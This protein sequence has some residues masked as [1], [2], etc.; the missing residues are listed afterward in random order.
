[1]SQEEEPNPF[2]PT[3]AS[4]SGSSCPDW[5]RDAKFG[6]WSHW[7]PQSVPRQGDW[8]ARGMYI[9]GSPH[10]RYHIR[11][12]GHP[13]EF[14]YKDV[15]RLWKAENFDPDA[16]MDL[17]VRAGA[18]YFVAQ[19]SHHDHFLN[20]ASRL[21][22][23][24]SVEVGPG[25]DIVGLWQA[26]ARRHG[27]PFGLSE[28]LAATFSW[29]PVNKAADT[30]GPWAGVPY[31][32]ADP[33]HED[34]Y[35][36]NR[37][38]LVPGCQDV[39]VSPWYTT[40]PWWHRRW[41]DL[42]TEMIDLYQP[43]LL[44]TDGP[45]PFFPHG[46]QPA[47][48]ATAHLYNTSAAAHDG[49]NQAVF[50]H[51]ERHERL[52]GFGVL[53]VERSQEPRV[54]PVPWQTDT[55]LGSWF[56]DVNAVYKTPAHVIEL[57]VDIVAKNGNLLLNVPQLPDGT[58]DR[59]CRHLLSELADWMAFHGE[60]IHGTR[61]FREG[62]EG[63]SGVTIDGFR[64]DRVPWTGADYRFTHRGNTVYAFQMAWPTDGRAV[65]HSVNTGDKVTRV[66]LLGTGA[67][68]LPFTRVDPTGGLVVS[69]PE[70]APAPYPTCL[71]IELE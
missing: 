31:D 18:K 62:V 51:K 21:H 9:E 69:L 44:Y 46:M 71:A 33:D 29:W 22:R 5:F 20:Y 15:T 8:Y 19:A 28:H 57:L 42:V 64:E 60:G 30:T 35:L 49:R 43:D 39:P 55:C 14:G 59:E 1:M 67:D 48:T 13:S 47:L 40:N 68:S 52:R 41:L 23:W 63:P 16:L 11:T 38:H 7:G 45:P 65:I 4:L 24:N 54:S 10:H 3:L 56:Y 17:Y 6:I 12:Y 2:L 70:R 58:I 66:R 32:G 53:D 37:E 26:A 61:P 50:A 25:K 27:L 36:P 34:L